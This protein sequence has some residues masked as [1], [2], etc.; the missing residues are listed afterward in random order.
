MLDCA[1]WHTFA[2]PGHCRAE[3]GG[4][5]RAEREGFPWDFWERLAWVGYR[6]SS[7]KCEGGDY[8]VFLVA[9]GVHAV[10]GTTLYREQ[11]AM[12]VYC[13]GVGLIGAATEVW[14]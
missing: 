10:I 9:T 6:V 8:R 3:E 12:K 1:A 7:R 2:E 11:G 14:D 13:G 4:A 5:T